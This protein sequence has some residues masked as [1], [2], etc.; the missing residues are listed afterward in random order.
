MK[1]TIESLGTLLRQRPEYRPLQE[2]RPAQK[3]FFAYNPRSRKNPPTENN[4]AKQRIQKILAA[5]GFGSRRA[6]EQ[7]VEDG[8]VEIDGE[9]VYKLPIVV[10][11]EVNRITVDDKPVRVQKFVYFLVNKPKG[12]FCTNSDPDGRRRAVDLMVG[13]RER[14]FPVGRLDAESMGLLIMTNDGDLALKLTHPRFRTPKTYR[15]EVKGQPTV[16]ALDKLRKGVWLADGRTGPAEIVVIHSSRK[17]SVLEITLR[18]GRNREI[19]RMLARFGHPVTRLTRIKMG[20]ISIRKLP[21]GS[22]RPLSDEEVKYLYRLAEGLEKGDVDAPRKPAGRQG[23]RQPRESTTSGRRTRSGTSRLGGRSSSIRGRR[24]EGKKKKKKVTRDARS[25][26]SNTTTT[27][28]HK[29]EEAEVVAKKFAKKFAKKKAASKNSQKT[30]RKA[31]KKVA[32]KVSKHVGKKKTTKRA[33]PKPNQ[34]REAAIVPRGGSKKKRRII[35]T[36]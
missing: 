10:D 17:N 13:V 16:E 1:K 20:R 28:A 19:R 4:M 14:I 22:Y 3:L 12:Y 9:P 36:D 23:G 8:R 34:D 25:G 24:S 35:F 7:L 11:P 26:G 2:S 5:A 21:L 30:P 15:A 27:K 29:L 33:V 32:Q 6:C 18:E 31:T